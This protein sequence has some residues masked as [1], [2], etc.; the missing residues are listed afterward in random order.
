MKAVS[1]DAIT[2]TLGVKERGEVRKEF[3]GNVESSGGFKL[4]NRE[5]WPHL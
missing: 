5:F 4:K 3:S 1:E 2:G